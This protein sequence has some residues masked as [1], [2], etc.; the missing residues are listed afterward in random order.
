MKRWMGLRR[1]CS[2]LTGAIGVGGRVHA[3]RW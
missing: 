1:A 2:V 3:D